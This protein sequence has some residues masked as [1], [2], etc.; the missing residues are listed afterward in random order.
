MRDRARK[1]KVQS[2]PLQLVPGAAAGGVS[3][4]LFL[5]DAPAQSSSPFAPCWGLGYI[6]V[7][8]YQLVLVRPYCW[9]ESPC[10]FP[11]FFPLQQ[12]YIFKLRE[13]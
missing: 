11:R 3:V 12:Y 13:L 7:I 9:P 10:I 5:A 4:Y 6:Y 1:G 8:I 2:W